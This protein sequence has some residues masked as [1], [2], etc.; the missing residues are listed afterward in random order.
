MV[1]GEELPVRPKNP[2]RA[3]VGDSTEAKYVLYYE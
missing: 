3:V 1:A 2:I